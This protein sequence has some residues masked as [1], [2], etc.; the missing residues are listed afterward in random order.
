VRSSA[1]TIVGLTAAGV[2]LYAASRLLDRRR[3]I[4]RWLVDASLV[5]HLVHQPIIL[6]PAVALFSVD[7]FG[8]VGW[9]VTVVASLVLSVGLYEMVNRTPGV[10]LLLTGRSA[11]QASLIPRFRRPRV[12]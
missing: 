6:A 5:V 8:L 2:A 7:V 4:I 11:R 9:T 3:R 10:R 12:A 1:W